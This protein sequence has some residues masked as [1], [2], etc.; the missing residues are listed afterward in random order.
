[1]TGRRSGAR[2]DR[3]RDAG[4]TLI[5]L[6]VGMSLFAIVSTIA[7]GAV[8]AAARMSDGT[9]TTNDLNEEA[10]NVLNRMSR[11][12][13]E[14]TRITA[15]SNPGGAGFSAAADSSV[16]LEVDFNGNG[17]IE[18]SA[19]DPEVLTY[20]YDR[21]ERQLL[22]Q[23]AGSTVPV[24]AG[25]VEGFKLRFYARA[26]AADRLSL[27]GLTNASAGTCGSPTA[28]KDNQLEWMELD[29]DPLRRFGDCSGT[30]TAAELPYISSVGLEVTVL[31][32]PR[33]QSYRTRV[34]L[35]NNRS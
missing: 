19:A 15:V 32:T 5:E 27:D 14:A 18:P 34:D 17:T 31:K 11:E 22:L 7:F 33:E 9:A 2:G 16:T 13:R 24:L 21:S 30:L 25:D 20:T 26:A 1:L 35:R 4:F 28:T 3:R 23:A 29:A 6:L 12:L 10:R 8:T